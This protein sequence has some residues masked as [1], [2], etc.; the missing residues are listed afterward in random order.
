M[1]VALST[2]F[3]RTA[4]DEISHHMPDL[5]MREYAIIVPL[6][7]LMYGWST[8]TQSF[9]PPIQRRRVLLGPIDAAVTFEE[10]GE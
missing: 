9:I 1:L 8:F 5:S 6:I 3:L 2:R 4:S 7:A 10:G